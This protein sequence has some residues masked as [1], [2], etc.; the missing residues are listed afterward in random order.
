MPPPQ[1]R[2]RLTF[3]SR[4]W[5]RRSAYLSRVIREGKMSSGIQLVPRAN[6]GTPLTEKVN[7]LPRS[8]APVSSWTV[9]NPTVPAHVASFRLSPDSVT[10]TGYS[11]CS[12]YPRG[13]HRLTSLTATSMTAEV[14]PGASVR[15]AD[16]PP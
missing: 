1:T 7:A 13:H 15:D 3:A 2:T 9:R 14:S 4:A 10:V 8:S 6:T 12:P 16:D 11:G 5:V